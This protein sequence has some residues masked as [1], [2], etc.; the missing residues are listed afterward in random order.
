MADTKL[1]L[2]QSQHP[3]KIMLQKTN[4]GYNWEIHCSG[5]DLAEILPKIREANAAL[6][7]EYLR[8]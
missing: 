1:V 2:H 3:L 8:G 7:K 5:R 4:S 6:K